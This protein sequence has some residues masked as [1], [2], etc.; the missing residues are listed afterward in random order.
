MFGGEPIKLGKEF[1]EGWGGPT[2]ERVVKGDLS[3]KVTSEQ[4][5]EGRE[6]TSQA[7]IQ[8]EGIQAGQQHMQRPGGGEEDV[9]A[10]GQQGPDRARPWG[11]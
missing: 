5:L 6:G 3:R 2:L 4:K 8:E 9:G 7:G 10:E 1:A 11:P